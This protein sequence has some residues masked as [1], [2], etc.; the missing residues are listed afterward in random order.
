MKVFCNNEK[1]GIGGFYM[2]ILEAI[3]ELIFCD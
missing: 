1:D 2:T 3:I